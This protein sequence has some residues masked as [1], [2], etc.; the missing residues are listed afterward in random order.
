MPGL[1]PWKLDPCR[2]LYDLYEQPGTMSRI[3]AQRLVAAHHRGDPYR[4]AVRRP[5]LPPSRGWSPALARRS[6][7]HPSCGEAEGDRRPEAGPAGGGCHERCDDAG[8][9][10][11][12]SPK[13]GIAR[14]VGS[15]SCASPGAWASWSGRGIGTLVSRRSG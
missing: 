10:I 3:V 8:R 15:P 1:S 7:H 4:Q 6:T 11:T 5:P 9:S 14:K 12:T 2:V 13:G